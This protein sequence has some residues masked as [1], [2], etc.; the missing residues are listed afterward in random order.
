M[1]LHI[2]IRKAI[3]FR[4]ASYVGSKNMKLSYKLS[5]FGHRGKFPNLIQPKDI[6]EHLLN[7]MLNPAFV[8]YAYYADKVKV[9]EYVKQ[10]GYEDILTKIY[11]IWNNP[12]EI[13][14]DILPNKFA[15]KANNG[16]GSHIFCT[17]KSK[18]N[19][20][21]TI[22]EIKNTLKLAS[23]EKFI[24][25]PHYQHIEPKVYCEEILETGTDEWPTDYKFHCVYGQPIDVFICTERKTN[26]KYCTYDLNWNKLDTTNDEYI[27]KV[28][29]EKPADLDNMIEIAKK[30]SEDFPFVRVDLYD[31]NGR[32]VF[33]ELTFTPWGGFMN[34]YTNKAIVEMGKHFKQPLSQLI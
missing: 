17:D 11:G 7:A 28:I 21:S 22:A 10:K 13:D 32:I 2:R 23:T 3:F 9:R 24:K 20:E 25:Q 1:K 12:E 27:S 29:P 34:S 19:I 6:S 5:Y 4:L 15:L 30:L 33:S 8:K 16:C 26:K 18:L 31:I 14:F